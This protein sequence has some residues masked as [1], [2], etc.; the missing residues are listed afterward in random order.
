MVERS[1]VLLSQNTFHGIHI[2][3][4]RKSKG[5]PSAQGL[6]QH[7]KSIVQVLHI[8]LLYE[9]QLRLSVS[10]PCTSSPWPGVSSPPFQ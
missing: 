3:Y 8:S 1:I 4:D 7:L 5:V 2:L 6:S 10:L 9:K